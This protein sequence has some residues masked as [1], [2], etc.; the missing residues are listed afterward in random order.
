MSSAAQTS[1]Q[2][3]QDLL[4]ALAGITKRFGPLIANDA[5]DLTVHK[6]EIVAGSAKVVQGLVKHLK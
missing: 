2:T 3:S 6:G 1:Q 5:I 4:L